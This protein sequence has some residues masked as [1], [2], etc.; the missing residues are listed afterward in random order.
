MAPPDP[1][2]DSNLM[3]LLCLGG[4]GPLRRLGSRELEGF[5]PSGRLGKQ[6]VNM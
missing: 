4:A 3:A 6:T 5:E 1:P 2:A